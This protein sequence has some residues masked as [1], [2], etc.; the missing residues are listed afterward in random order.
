MVR[1]SVAKYVSFI[2][3]TVGVLLSPTTGR[4]RA[5]DTSTCAGTDCIEVATQFLPYDIVRDNY[6]HFV[7]DRYFAFDV[8]I[9]NYKREKT[10]YIKAFVFA[11]KKNTAISPFLNVDAKL[12]RGSIEKGQLVGR[13]NVTI[14]VL[15][16][17]GTVASGLSGFFKVAESAAAAGRIIAAYNGPAI[18]GIGIIVPDTTVKYLNN[19]DQDQV[20]KNGFVVGGNETQRGRVF[21]PIE[22]LFPD[23]RKG[24]PHVKAKEFTAKDLQDVIG[25]VRPMGFSAEKATILTRSDSRSVQ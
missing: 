1:S 22:A 18:T 19:W 23:F 5:E 3:L 14:E 20:L 25:E 24:C 7:A 16:T 10:L 11:Q 8:A 13:R 12:V 21:L 15:K 6:G 2:V 17:V 4:A 9:A